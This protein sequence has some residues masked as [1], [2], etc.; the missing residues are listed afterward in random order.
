MHR[1]KSAL[2]FWRQ[3]NATA[4]MTIVELLVV[5]MI[6][7]TLSAIAAPGWKAFHSNRG[8]SA[9]QDE[10][11]QAIRQTQSQ[12]MQSH[13]VWQVSFQDVGNKVQWAMYPVISSTNPVVWQT[14]FSEVDIDTG[15]TTLT[16]QNG[17]YRLQFDGRGNVNGALG[18]LTFSMADSSSK[19][20]IVASTLLGALR[21][22]ADQAC[23]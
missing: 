23:N 20:C 8:L 13:R 3:K 17:I 7:G 14:L 11:F 19:R 2:R 4:G 1:S 9:A 21:K 10:A 16:Q 18:K 12:A 22:V 6:V 5:V 15:L